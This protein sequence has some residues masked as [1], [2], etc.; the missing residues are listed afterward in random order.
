MGGKSRNLTAFSL[1]LAGTTKLYGCTT[2]PCLKCY[3]SRMPLKSA[4]TSTTRA[5]PAKGC[6]KQFASHTSD[7]TPD[8]ICSTGHTLDEFLEEFPSVTRDA[9]IV[10]LE[11]AKG[12]VI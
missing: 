11:Y 7:F 12:L 5:N 1:P 4:I 3:P 9:A 2:R 6:Y 8:G 10:A